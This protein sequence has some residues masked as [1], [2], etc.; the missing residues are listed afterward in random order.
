MS[1]Q[2]RSAKAGVFAKLKNIKL[3]NKVHIEYGAATWPGGSDLA[4]DA[5]YDDI[6][7]RGISTL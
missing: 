2:I 7:L 4:P 5:M 6:K 3:F 1:Q